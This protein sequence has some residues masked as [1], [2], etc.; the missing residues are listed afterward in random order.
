MLAVHDALSREKTYLVQ[1]V[2]GV[3]ISA[4]P[5]SYSARLR[6]RALLTAVEAGEAAQKSGHDGEA[7]VQ[8]LGLA[9]RLAQ[10]KRSHERRQ[11][12]F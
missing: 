1:E 6:I 2:Y 5:L 3:A 10:I 7:G 4:V 11:G 9:T 12:L 8:H